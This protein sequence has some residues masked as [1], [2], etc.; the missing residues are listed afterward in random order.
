MM[1][2]RPAGGHKLLLLGSCPRLFV[3]SSDPAKNLIRIVCGFD[4]QPKPENAFMN[5]KALGIDSKLG[6][7]GQCTV[8][9]FS[10]RARAG[11]GENQPQPRAFRV[12][13]CHP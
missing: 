8:K 10:S 6:I 4:H 11:P 5:E 2:L 13:L 12:L 7:H 1:Y 3:E 9:K